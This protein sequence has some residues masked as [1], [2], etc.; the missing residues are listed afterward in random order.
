MGPGRWLLPTKTCLHPG[1]QQRGSWGR[2][3]AST[4]P[5]AHTTVLELW[6]RQPGRGPGLQMQS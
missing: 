6:A 1:R 2:Q 4:D 3:L 5:E